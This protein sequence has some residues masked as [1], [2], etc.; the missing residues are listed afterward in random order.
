MLYY[1]KDGRKEDMW[2]AET[3]Q[4]MCEVENVILST[5]GYERVCLNA[6][7]VPFL[8]AI[9]HP[10]G[11]ELRATLNGSSGARCSLP[12]MSAVS[13]FYQQHEEAL[14]DEPL[15]EVFYGTR[16]PKA[17]TRLTSASQHTRD[18]ALLDEGYVEARRARLYELALSSPALRAQ[19]GFFLSSASLEEGSAPR[20]TATRSMIS[21]GSPLPGFADAE[22]REE[23]EEEIIEEWA[24]KVEQR[25]FDHFDMHKGAHARRAAPRPAPRLLTPPLTPP[26]AP[27]LAPPLTLHQTPSTRPTLAPPNPPHTPRYT[28]P[29]PPPAPSKTPTPTPP[30]RRAS[31]GPSSTTTSTRP[32]S[33]AGS[34]RK[35]SRWSSP[36]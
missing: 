3:L 28:S 32:S 2:T 18:C 30:S 15:F 13:L 24:L 27:P 35:T 29:P 23:E 11:L 26:L 5:P 36:R 4:Q 33:S 8:S 12:H 34:P 19:V 1:W 6:T 22:D 25:L 31:A 21:F 10:P 20:T 16:E 9:A 17:P 14:G 7:V